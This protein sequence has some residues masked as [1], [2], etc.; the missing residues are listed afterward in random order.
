MSDQRYQTAADLAL[1][2]SGDIN[3]VRVETPYQEFP[4]HLHKLNAK[5]KAIAIVVTNEDEKAAGLKAGFQL[6]GVVE[7]V[8]AVVEEDAELEAGAAA[9]SKAGSKK[10]K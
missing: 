5:G 6:E 7:A 8:E 9:V 10:G 1:K 4:R 3:K 2:D